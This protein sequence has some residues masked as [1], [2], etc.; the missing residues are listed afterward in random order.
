MKCQIGASSFCIL[1][2]PF[3][4]NHAA[5]LL[6]PTCLHELADEVENAVNLAVLFLKLL[7]S[8]ALQLGDALFQFLVY[9]QHVSQLDERL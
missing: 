4:T 5:L 9:S 3:E 2:L 6:L 1:A 7:T 8:A